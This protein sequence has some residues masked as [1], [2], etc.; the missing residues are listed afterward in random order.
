MDLGTFLIFLIIFGLLGFII[1]KFVGFNPYRIFTDLV[2]V[3]IIILLLIAMWPAI[4]T[5]EKSIETIPNVVDVFANNLP[6]ILIGD[7][8]GS[9]IGAITD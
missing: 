9:F 8:A 6:G 7:L 5:P 4:I 2:A 1:S 3:V